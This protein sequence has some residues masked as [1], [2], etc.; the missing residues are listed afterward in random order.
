[1]A[2]ARMSTM[3]MKKVFVGGSTGLVGSAVIRYLVEHYPS[4][5]IR[6]S[7]RYS[8][9]VCENGN[10]EY[11]RADLTSE[12]DCRLAVQGCDCAIMAAAQTSGAGVISTQPWNLVN[13]NL[14]MN[15][16]LLK[17]IAEAGIRRLVLIGSATLYQDFEGII[18]ED[19]LDLNLDPPSAYYGV[20][21]V[22]RY[23]EKLCS[24]WERLSDLRVVVIRASN[25]FGPRARFDSRT[26]NFIPALIRKAVDK[27][28]PFVVWGSPAVDRDVI[29][30]DDLVRSI[31]M[32]LE[33]QDITS[34]VFNIGSGIKTTVGAVVYWALKYAGH[35]PVRI[36]YDEQGHTTVPSRTIDCTKAERILGWKPEISVEEGIQKT[37]DWWKANR[38]SWKK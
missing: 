9:P 19:Q 10:V 30:V 11:V 23:I 29:Y 26:S 14:F 13:P 3:Q 1:M 21:W 6:A 24:F 38:N 36:I 8:A 35:T 32:I 20:G 25:I 12:A 37:V 2:T 4:L 34:D 27:T 28:D 5:P 22:A 15:A 7:L 18:S 17:E 31:A 33:R 16:V